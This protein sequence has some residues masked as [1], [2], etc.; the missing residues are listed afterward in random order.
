MVGIP[1]ICV[2]IMLTVVSILV[3]RSIKEAE[4]T[5]M[6]FGDITDKETV[7]TSLV[8]VTASIAHVATQ[9][10]SSDSRTSISSGSKPTSHYSSP[11]QSPVA[12]PNGRTPLEN[13][14]T[15]NLDTPE[16]VQPEEVE[17][18]E[19]VIFRSNTS[20]A[21]APSSSRFQS[22]TS[23][24]HLVTKSYIKPKTRRL[25]SLR[26]AEGVVSPAGKQGKYIKKIT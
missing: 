9:G 10:C 18:H 4:G 19:M 8:N 21:S 26:K 5:A 15:V 25:R 17:Q 6:G 3:M 13:D 24:D 11:C 16:K 1:L 23:L 22:T 2:T 20:L 14:T 12:K 7:Q